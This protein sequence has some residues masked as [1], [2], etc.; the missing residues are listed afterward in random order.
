M[1]RLPSTTTSILPSP[2]TSDDL[3]SDFLHIA[4]SS[5]ISEESD[6]LV[7][8][9]ERVHKIHRGTFQKGQNVKGRPL[10]TPSPKNRL[11]PIK[12]KSKLFQH[13]KFPQPNKRY[14]IKIRKDYTHSFRDL[15]I[16]SS[17]LSN[18]GYGHT[19]HS[20]LYTQLHWCKMQRQAKPLSIPLSWWVT[21]MGY[22]MGYSHTCYWSV[23]LAVEY[24]EYCAQYVRIHYLRAMRN[25]YVDHERSECSP[26][27][28]W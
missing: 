1:L 12:A 24:R 26:Y 3:R 19:E 22:V 10:T 23:L 20:I 5:Q 27:E 2:L 28:F 13:V 6:I 21:V 18:N 16:C 7:P 14:S 15:R 4:L 17:W 9:K 11:W 25:I 8:G